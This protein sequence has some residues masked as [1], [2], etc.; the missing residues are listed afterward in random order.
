LLQ[1]FVKYLDL[2]GDC[3]N[4]DDNEHLSSAHNIFQP[5]MTL[6]S[7]K[8]PSLHA[9]PHACITILRENVLHL[10]ISTTQKQAPVDAQYPSGV[11]GPQTV[12]NQQSIKRLKSR[13]Q[14]STRRLSL[15]AS[16]TVYRQ[17]SEL[18]IRLSQTPPPS[19]HHL[20]HPCDTS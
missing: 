12:Q 20:R 2:E 5:P 15:A 4:K 14:C 19:P 11:P 6:S 13:S 16:R 18:Q 3:A 9:F 7:E 1:K 8:M 17:S 10:Q